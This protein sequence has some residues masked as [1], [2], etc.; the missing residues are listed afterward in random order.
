MS[1]YKYPNKV[2]FYKFLFN[3]TAINKNPIPF[4]KKW[5]DMHDDSFS[6]ISPFRGRVILTRNATLS[7]QILQK[8]HKIY[9][10]SKI[11]TKFL[12]KYIGYGLLTSSGEYWLKQRRLIQPG[13]HKEKIKNLVSIINN[14]IREQVDKIETDTYV[15][16]YPIMHELAFE[17]V[18]KSLF[19]YS[20]EKK[21]LRRLQVIIEQLQQFI[22]KEIRQP[23]KKL[24]YVLK[25]DIRYHMKLV[26]ESRDI[27]NAVI[28]NRKQSKE[29][30]DDLLEML[31]N[32]K[33][34]DGLSMTNNQLIDEIL[35]LFVAGHETTANALTF[36]LKLLAQNQDTLKKIQAEVD[37]V[38]STN[39]SLLDT[40]L[41]LK[42]T[43]S[44]IDESLRLYPPAWIT[45]RVA[46]KD[47]Q[48]GDYFLKKG[49]IIGISIYEL[50]RSVSYWKNPDDFIPERFI[51]DNQRH[52]S[53]YYL[54]FGAG[55]RLCIG[56]DFAIYE[57]ILVINEI[58]KRFD[59]STN[60]NVIKVNPLI[61][62]K[63]VG[64]QLKF[65]P[66]C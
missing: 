50:H 3:S 6:V 12:S 60:N 33:Y 8:Q 21:T 5:F 15:D 51:E 13:F 36:T 35:I 20:A 63:P 34:E 40:I 7:K 10:K 42:F 62:L 29:S 39:S 2:P 31:L 23:H 59:I 1:Q 17:V 66:K 30:H 11:Q 18:A 25:G 41:K 27:I 54:P 43:R 55:P 52:K 64:L 58:I 28:E 9:H 44:C 47:N 38:E 16:L 49:T 46:V 61:T 26:K 19:N 37:I 56:N 45:D 24:W 32:A 53:G 4:Y 57:M 48:L 22:V 65:T 14:T